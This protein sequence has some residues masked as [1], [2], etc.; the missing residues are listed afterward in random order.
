MTPMNHDKAVRE[1]VIAL[2]NTNGAHTDFETAIKDIPAAIRGQRPQGA[3]HS[4][5]EVLEHLRIAQWDILEF[6]R[7]PA[8]VSP[9]FPAGYWPATQTPADDK[10]WDE[11][12][13]AFRRDLKAMAALIANK[14]TDLFAPLPN[15]RAKTILREALVLADHNGYHLGELV[16][17]RRMLGAGHCPRAEPP[18]LLRLSHVIDVALAIRIEVALH[19]VIA[20]AA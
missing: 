6:S 19:Q 20:G 1:H 5:W 7:N 2:L 14:S 3:E 8:H 15:D 10:A 12:V 9:E 13:N 11:S 4:L 17:S 16:L 18:S